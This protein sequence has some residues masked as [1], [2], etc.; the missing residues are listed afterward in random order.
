ML[1]CTVKD[2]KY[3]AITCQYILCIVKPLIG[4]R[5]TKMFGDSAKANVHFTNS[6]Y[7]KFP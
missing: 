5:G 7:F 6:L 1:Y 3:E 2:N 4:L